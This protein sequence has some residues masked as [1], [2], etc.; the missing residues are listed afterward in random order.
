MK[1]AVAS[2]PDRCWLPRSTPNRENGPGSRHKFTIKAEST[3]AKKMAFFHGYA[4]SIAKRL[5][6]CKD[7]TSSARSCVAVST[8][9]GAMPA[10]KACCHLAA[11]KHHLSPALRPGKSYSGTGVERSFPASLEKA[12]NSSVI[13]TQ[14]VW[15]PKSRGAVLQQPS[16][17]N[18]VTGDSEHEHSGSPKTFF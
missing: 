13:T 7:A 4:R 6:S 14:T 8:T 11:H 3:S 2:K 16:R 12:R 10:S 5:R 1:D 18:P 17:K 9:F 15:E